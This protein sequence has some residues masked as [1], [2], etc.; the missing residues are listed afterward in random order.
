[1]F[2]HEAVSEEDCAACHRPHGSQHDKLLTQDGNGLCLQCHV[3]A[4][5][6][7]TD[8]WEIGEQ[9]HAGL[10]LSEGRCYDCHTHV[11]GSNV[12]PTLQDQ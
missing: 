1:M 3:D 12:S 8:G 7:A 11:H 6:N 2:E 9:S 4:H 5:L 10:L